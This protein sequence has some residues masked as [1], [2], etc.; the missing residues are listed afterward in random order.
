MCLLDAYT[1]NSPA[2]CGGS[3]NVSA[4]L[5]CKGEGKR[6]AIASLYHG[7]FPALADGFTGS[8]QVAAGKTFVDCQREACSKRRN[9]IHLLE[10]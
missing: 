9:G 3:R 6:C 10:S 8:L 1:W 2:G 7:M 4:G 5:H